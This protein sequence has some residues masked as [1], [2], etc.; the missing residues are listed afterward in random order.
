[1][2]NN[3]LGIRCV[4]VVSNSFG[5]G[6][7]V[8]IKAVIDGT[9]VWQ[10]REIRT[11]HG[12]R[13]QNPTVADFGLGDASIIDSIIVLWPSGFA[14]TTADILP[15]QRYSVVEGSG[16]LCVGTDSDADGW[17]DV[18][19]ACPGDNCPDIFNP[20][21]N[22]VDDDGIGDTCD[23]DIDGDGVLNDTDN[24]PFVDNAGQ[25]DADSDNVG[26]ACDNCPDDANPLQED[27]D[28]DGMGDA[29][30]ICPFDPLNDEDGDE[31]CGDVDNCHTNYNPG[32]EDADENGIGDVCDCNCGLL[33]GDV[34]GDESVNPVDVA[35]MVN[36]VYLSLDARVVP[37]SCPY[38][39]GDVDCNEI[40]NPLD[41]AFYTNYVYKGLTPFPCAGCE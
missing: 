30:D 35:Y 11:N 15:N 20:D 29:C 41:V 32:Q 13:S 31:I 10:L 1:M 6:A 17:P 21:Q 38:E 9:P 14:D 12:H 39:P 8:R 40:V 27:N 24:C 7:K 4:G 28:D 37:P 26:D 33:W 25:D 16:L 36:Y 3:W 19:D 22:D 5:V 23:D 2:G 18:A 34:T